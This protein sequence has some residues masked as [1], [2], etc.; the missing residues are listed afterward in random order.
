MR[1][2]DFNPDSPETRQP[3]IEA[4][5]KKLRSQA[6]WWEGDPR[7]REV[8]TELLAANPMNS[9]APTTGDVQFDALAETG[10]QA[11]SLANQFAAERD[12]ARAEAARLK[13]RVAELT[14]E[15]AHAKMRLSIA[16]LG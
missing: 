7:A 10:F 12:D 1:S 16:G 5:I 2:H 8:L 6:G 4:A 3:A 13:T 11:V 9:P 15:L 14:G